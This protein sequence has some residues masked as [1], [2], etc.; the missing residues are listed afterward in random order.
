MKTRIT[1]LLIAVACFVCLFITGCSSVVPARPAQEMSGAATARDVKVHYIDVG[2]GDAILIHTPQKAI[3]IDSGDLIEG[4]KEHP[5]VTYLKSQGIKTLDAVIIT[6]PHADHIG[7]MQAVFDAFTIKQVYDSGQTTTTQIYKHYLQRIKEQKISFAL[8]RAGNSVDLGDGISLQ[9]LHPQE[10][11]MAGTGADLNNNSVVVRLVFGEISF[12]FA[13]DIEK[14]AESTLAKRPE[15]LK[16]TILKVGHHG[17]STSSTAAFIKTVGPE[18]AVI[19]CGN[20]NDY[21][22]PHA[23]TLKKYE[24]LKINLYRTDLRGSVIITTDGKQYIVKAD[25]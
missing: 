24:Q 20:N 25:R 7:G 18:T 10:P 3:L 23:G 22:H 19:M 12:L 9:F 6:H 13:G 21:H 8:A 15:A 4:K 14:E 1:A 16:S 5:V 17:S 2:Q 11:L